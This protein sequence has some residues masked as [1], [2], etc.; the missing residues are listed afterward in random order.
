ML[1][2]PAAWTSPSPAPTPPTAA[3]G[4][5]RTVWGCMAVAGASSCAAS[6]VALAALSVLATPAPEV[7]CAHL[8][9]DVPDRAKLECLQVEI[10][11]GDTDAIL[12]ALDWV[13]T[14]RPDHPLHAEG[15]ELIAD[16]SKRL[17]RTA[18]AA[19]KAG[20]LSQAIAR[21]EHIPPSSPR[22]SEARFRLQRLRHER[23]RQRLALYAQAQT[24]LQQQDWGQAFRAL[25]RLQTLEA[26]AERPGLSPTL[27][28]Q[29]EA[30]RQGQRLLDQALRTHA[31]GTAERWGEAI[32]IASRIDPQSYVGQSAQPLMNRWSDDL[33]PYATYRF[34]QGDLSHARLLL[35]LMAQ[36]PDRRA[37]AQDWLALVQTRQLAEA[38]LRRAPSGVSTAV[39]LYPAILAARSIRPETGGPSPAI[40]DIQGWQTQLRPQPVS[41]HPP[42]RLSAPR[43]VAVSC[44]P[45]FLS[46][47]GALGNAIAQV[48][49]RSCPGL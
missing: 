14:W 18:A 10:A 34:R 25:W 47:H 39:G 23:N 5:N 30:E 46:G 48:V 32:A 21:I 1:T 15:Q 33:L 6:S 26:G 4:G 43:S 35:R 38:S 24:A 11:A 3:T 41:A 13:G 29:I 19:Q 36:N 8:P 31:W 45:A 27:A 40:A 9:T 28:R 42:T 22:F 20:R 12:T 16:W 44:R 37:L 2:S 7:D 17:F 49:A